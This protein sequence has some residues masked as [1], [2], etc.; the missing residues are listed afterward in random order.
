MRKP[1]PDSLV[2]P[3]TSWDLIQDSL[4]SVR[5]TDIRGKRCIYLE[6][7]SEADS[8]TAQ[9][10]WPG[11]PWRIS[12]SNADSLVRSGVPRAG[13]AIFPWTGLVRPSPSWSD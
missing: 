1:Q 5:D 2:V 7:A 3:R 12:V 4:D 13:P 6:G 10:S 9:V 8:E 11:D